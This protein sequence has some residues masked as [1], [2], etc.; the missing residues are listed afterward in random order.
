MHN[1]FYL[2]NNLLQTPIQKVLGQIN[3]NPYVACDGFVMC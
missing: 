1:I 2:E 3:K